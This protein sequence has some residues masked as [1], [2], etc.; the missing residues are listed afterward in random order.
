[1]LAESTL[2]VIGRPAG[3]IRVDQRFPRQPRRQLLF[4]G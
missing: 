4:L 3:F 2:R 1:M